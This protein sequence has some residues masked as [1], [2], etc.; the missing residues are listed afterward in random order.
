[1]TTQYRSAVV[2]ADAGFEERQAQRQSHVVKYESGLRDTWNKFL[3]ASKN[4]TFLF[5]RDFL[6]YHADRFVDC[7]LMVY[8]GAEL[9]AVLPANLAGSTLVSHGGLTYGGLV[10]RRDASLADV[11]RSFRAVLAW[12]ASQG[13]MT[14]RYKRIPRV[15]SVLPDDEIDYLHFLVNATLVRRDLSSTIAIGRDALPCRK[16]RKSSIASAA[17][18][19]CTVEQTTDFGPFWDDVLTPTLQERHRVAPVHSL[20]EMSLLASRFPTHISQFN[21]CHFGTVVA[22][23]T[24]FVTETVAHTQYL[25]ATEHGRRLGALDFLIDRLLRAEYAGKRYFDF[26]ISNEQGGRLVNAG[27]LQWKEGFG[28]R[29]V[30]HD[31]Y[32]I[33]TGMFGAIDAAFESRVVP[34]CGGNGRPSL[35]Q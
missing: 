22:G 20:Q 25:A 6:E 29:G 11:A 12:A 1:M 18:H 4:A 3:G 32:D 13:I 35:K 10:V 31:L 5:H 28:A 2:G 34:E 23:A 21:V 27:L 30:C 7:S 26:G 9:T 19:G 15:Y 17:R 16:G 8:Q 24:M 14:L 33:Q